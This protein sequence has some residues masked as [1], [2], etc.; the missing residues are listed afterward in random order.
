MAWLTTYSTQSTLN[1][2]FAANKGNI[3]M[4]HLKE[5]LKTAGW[6]VI[7]SSDGTTY[8]AS[9]DQISSSDSG[10]GGMDNNN[11]WFRIQDPGTVREYVFQRGTT[12]QAWKWM[13]S[14]SD[15]F[16]GGTP[17]ATTVP[18]ATDEQ[19]LAKAGTSAVTM[20]PTGAG[21]AH[22]A[23]QNAAHNGV[24]AWWLMVSQAGTTL[25]EQTLMCCDAM[26]ASLSTG[27]NDPCV[28]YGSDDA[29]VDATVGSTSVASTTDSFRGWMRYNETDEEWSGLTAAYYYTATGVLYTPGF[30]LLNPH[31]DKFGLLPIPY[32]R[33]SSTGT[34]VGFKGLGKYIK[35]KPSELI[36]YP[37][38]LSDV[39]DNYV[40]CYDVAL[41]G[42]PSG[43]KFRF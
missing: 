28:H 4:Y 14:A 16:T 26:D 1:I 40:V 2:G 38:V 12:S 33:H 43:F 17:N 22:I 24:Y 9:G 10:A 42:V 35:W 23:V 18:T 36:R 15:K 7:S 27:D 8:N 37:S 5:L 6:S 19:G 20:L 34:T 32:F 25:P 13:Y 21:F 39:S 30:G 3:M 29:P 31:N 41:P 11:A